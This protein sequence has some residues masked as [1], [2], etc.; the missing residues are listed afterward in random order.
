MT[1]LELRALFAYKKYNK[2]GMPREARE[3][4]FE[5]KDYV[6]LIFDCDENPIYLYRVKNNGE[7]KSLKR[8]PA[9]FKYEE[10]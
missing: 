3:V 4:E 6:V 1:D 8:F 9:N 7:L 10:K 2:G 5:G